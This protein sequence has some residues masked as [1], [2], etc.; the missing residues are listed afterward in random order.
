MRDIY[1]LNDVCEMAAEDGIVLKA[2]EED[3][4]RSHGRIMSRKRD[5]QFIFV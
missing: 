2:E 5:N 1:R 4:K 3:G